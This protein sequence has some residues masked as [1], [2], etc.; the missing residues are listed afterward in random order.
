[1]CETEPSSS[2]CLGLFRVFLILSSVHV[3]KTCTETRLG[4]GEQ[5]S[6]LPV[7]D[8]IKAVPIPPVGFSD[9]VTAAT[10]QPIT[11]QYP[12]RVRGSKGR[13]Q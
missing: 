8:V 7:I 6:S 1:M 2:G 10:D 11:S 12:P 3:H 5:A 13:G 4:L 9:Y